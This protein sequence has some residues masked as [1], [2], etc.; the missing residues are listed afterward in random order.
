MGQAG[1][2]IACELDVARRRHARG[3]LDRSLRRRRQDQIGRGHRRHLDAQIDA[4]HQ[5]A[6]DARLVIAGAAVDAA[7]LAGIAGLERIAAA[8]WIHRRDQHEAGRVGDAMIG[9]RHRDLAV[10]QRLAQGIQHARIEFG[11]LVEE[12]HALM[13]Q[14]DLAGLGADAA[15]GERSHAGGMMRRA[16][17]PPRRQRA[18]FDLAGNGG[19][20]RDLEQLRH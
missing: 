12:Q 16:E 20:H 15:A 19:D 8:T 5:R 10:L 11:Q 14:R 17:R 13:R 9:A 2:G 18:A 7:A 1:I 4:V 3:D 6:R